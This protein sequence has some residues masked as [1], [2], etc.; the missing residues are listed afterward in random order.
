MFHCLTRHVGTVDI[1]HQRTVIAESNTQYRQER[2][3]NCVF[4][5]PAAHFLSDRIH[6]GHIHVDINTN[7]RLADGV[8]RNMQTLFFLKQRFVELLHLGHIHIDAK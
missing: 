5:L 7:H 4:L 8:Q 6:K 1:F 2:N 3:A